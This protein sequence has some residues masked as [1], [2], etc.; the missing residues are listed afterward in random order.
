M[1]DKMRQLREL[2]EEIKK[3][4]PEYADEID[5]IM[6]ELEAKHKDLQKQA[7]HKIHEAEQSQGSHM[8][9]KAAK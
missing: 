6:A 9:D 2:A 5:R 8:F 4:H 7:K 3:K 1:D